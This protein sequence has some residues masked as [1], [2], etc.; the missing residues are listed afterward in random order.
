MKTFFLMALL[1]VLLVFIGGF[2]GGQNGMFIAFGFALLMNFGSYWFSDKL[3]LRMY[4]ASEVQQGDNPTL[5]QMVDDLRQRAGLPMPKVYVIPSAQPNAFA[6]GRDP[7][8][9]AVAVSQGI[10]RLISKDELRGVIGHELAHIKHRDI[11]V[12]TVAA[13]IAGAISMLANMAQW[14][15][16]FGGGRSS[17]DREGGHPI[18]GLVMMVVAPIAAMMIQMA[19]SRSRE[20]LADEGGAQI[21]GNPLSLANALR[22]LDAAAHEIPMQASPATAHMFIV[23]PLSGGGLMKLFSTHPPMEERIARLEAMVYGGVVA[24]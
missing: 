19:I 23:N 3:V 4:K 12:G 13:T 7:N 14:A 8:H 22:R 1:T 20:F 5:Y 9:A 15:F 17:D 18:A 24:G 11:L 10:L 16:M 21:S 2:V 6:T